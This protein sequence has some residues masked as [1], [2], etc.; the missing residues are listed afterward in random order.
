M[1]SVKKEEEVIE[2]VKKEVK[3]VSKPKFMEVSAE[4]FEIPPGHSK[5]I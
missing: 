4:S 5:R 2:E 3:G 1:Y